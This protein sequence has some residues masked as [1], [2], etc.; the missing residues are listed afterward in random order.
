MAAEEHM[1]D[2]GSCRS[3]Y[4]QFPDHNSRRRH[5]IER[6]KWGRS[7]RSCTGW[8]R[9][10]TGCSKVIEPRICFQGYNRCHC[11]SIRHTD[12]SEPM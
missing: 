3:E 1:W 2:T 6:N 4:T 7:L 8:D 12:K 9:A 10:G 11:D 5:C